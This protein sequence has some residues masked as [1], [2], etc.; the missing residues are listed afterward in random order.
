M[1]RLIDVADLAQVSKATA[2][3]VLSGKAA[4]ERIAEGTVHRVEAAAKKLQY[5]PNYRAASLSSGKTQV[6][7]VVLGEIHPHSV[8][9]LFWSTFWDYL[10]IAAQKQSYHLLAIRPNQKTSL[11][12]AS[13]FAAERRIDGLIIPG[14]FYDVSQAKRITVPQVY[15]EVGKQI[16]YPQLNINPELGIREALEKLHQQ[17]IRNIAH[18]Y[19]N[20]HRTGILR[21]IANELNMTC[22][23]V[24]ISKPEIPAHSTAA[25]YI[26][27]YQNS[28][29]KDFSKSLPFDH[30][31]AFFCDNDLIALACDT[32]RPDSSKCRIIGF[33]GIYTNYS[34]RSID[35]I[36][37]PFQ[38]MS[39]QA[40]AA[41]L[42]HAIPVNPPQSFYQAATHA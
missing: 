25:A 30:H 15:L 28:L 2:S 11:E 5:R 39:E 34:Q 16:K 35:S 9:H 8:S 32:L 3:K 31:E 23:T 12:N 24:K 33:D 20:K 36:V 4:N 38:E 17:G 37:Y 29:K 14:F 21:G 7:G 22:N 42:G 40:I 1:A 18:C 26:H 6:L 19:H 13:E 41:A 10:E 27:S